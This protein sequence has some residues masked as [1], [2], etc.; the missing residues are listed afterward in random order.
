M[1]NGKKAITNQQITERYFHIGPYLLD[2]LTEGLYGKIAM[3]TFTMSQILVVL[4]KSDKTPPK[5]RRRILQ[6]LANGIKNER[7]HQWARFGYIDAVV[8]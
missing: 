8:P 1:L 2:V 4:G 7:S 6:I 5:L 3:A